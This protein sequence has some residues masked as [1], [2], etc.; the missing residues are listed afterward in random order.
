MFSHMPAQYD[1]LVEVAADNHGLVRTEDAVELGLAPATLTRLL[2]AGRIERVTR[3]LYRVTAL[4]TDR[5]TPY[6][7]AVLWA[8]GR[9]AISHASAL[10]MMELCDVVPRRIHITVREEY[11]PRK[12]GGDHYRVHRHTLPLADVTYYEGVPVVT[13]YRAIHQAIGD[14]ED[15]DQLQTAVRNASRQGLLLR[16]EAARLWA[17]LR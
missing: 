1:T 6:M 12:A 3:G 17:R 7:Q 14:G 15:P 13:A 8:N 5:L 9:A 10:E 16:G 11:N 2:A 4:P